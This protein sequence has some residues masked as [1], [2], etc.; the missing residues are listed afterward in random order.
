MKAKL[1]SSEQPLIS[2]IV[3]VSR[4]NTRFYQICLKGDAGGISF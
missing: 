4:K 1:Y 2:P 3:L